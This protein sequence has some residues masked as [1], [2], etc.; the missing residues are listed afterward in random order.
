MFAAIPFPDISPE[1]FAVDIGGLHLAIRWYALGYI[2]GILIGWWI[3]ARAIAA[4]ALWRDAAPMTKAQLEELVTWMVISIIVGGR[5]GFVLFYQPG[6]YLSHP[7][8]IPKV[9]MGGMAFHGGFLGVVVGVWLFSRKHKL[10][11]AS[12]ADLLALATPPALGLVRVANFINAELWGRPTDLP[13]GVI[14]PGELAQSC[15]TAAAPC[16]RHPSQLYEAGL[17]GLVLMLVLIVLAWGRGWLKVPGRIAGTFFL[18]YGMSRFIVE[19][20]RQADPQYITPDDPFGQV[21]LGMTMGQLLSLPMVLAG[22][23]TILWAN[24]RARA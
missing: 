12:I 18:G 23:L 15:A 13:W 14:F 8:D 3:I 16:A 22:I 5:L 4:P 10:A 21:F 2:V 7:L 1:L 20:F 9:W 11:T 19:F 17:E 24:R 6:Y